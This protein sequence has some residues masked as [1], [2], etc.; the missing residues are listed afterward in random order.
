MVDDGRRR[1][2]GG[3]VVRPRF[4]RDQRRRRAA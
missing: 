4:G 3:S 2:R 1:H